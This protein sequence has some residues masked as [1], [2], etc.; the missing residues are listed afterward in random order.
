[1]DP[2]FRFELPLHSHEEK[3]TVTVLTTHGGTR[4]L[5]RWGEFR[6]R[7]GEEECVLQ[8]YRTEAGSRR[9][10]LPFRDGTA[11]IETYVKGRYIDL[12]PEI[13]HTEEG[14]WIVDFNEAYNPWCE[15][16][17]DFVCPHA[18]RE[19][20]LTPPIRAGEKRFRLH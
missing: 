18:P 7:I 1:V 5:I 17:D 2:A 15:Y 6:F 4:N 8:A 10:F 20:W 16:S 12:E 19:N 13:H 14:W 11:G 9:L 3:A